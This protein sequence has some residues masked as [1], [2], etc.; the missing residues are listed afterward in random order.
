MLQTK[1]FADLVDEIPLIAEVEQV[2]CV[3][4]GHE[5]RGTGGGLRQ[6][7][8]LQAAALVAGGLHPGGSAGQ[9]LVQNAGGH[10]GAVL[11]IHIPDQ[12]HQHI[13]AGLGRDEDDG[14]VAHKAETLGIAAALQLHGV[15]L[16][17][18]HG[19]PLVHH[20]NA[21][22]ALL[23]GVASHLAVLLG[24]ADGSIHKDQRHA[25]ALHSGQCTHHHVAL[26]AIAD[27]AALAQTCG[28]GK[29][30]LAV[31]VVHRG[32]D[33]IT[34]GAGLV[35]NDHAV[36]AQ[37]AVGQ[38]GLAHVGATDDGNRD[39]VLLYHGLAEVQM[40]AHG[41]QQITRAVTVHG[42]NGH[43]LV[44]TE[45][46]ELVQLHGSLAH[47]VALVHGKNNG[48]VAAAQH[49]RHILIGCGQAVAHV[50]DHDDAVGGVNG[51]LRLLA[52]VGQNALGS[53]WLDA[54]GI[55]QQ[56]LVAVP[57]A[58]GKNAVAGNARGILHN[59]KAL[60]AQLIEQGGFAH[61]GAAH[62]CYDRFA[63]GVSSFL[64]RGKIQ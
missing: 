22:L 7:V 24:K 55:H 25:A 21:G 58:V 59:G 31:G 41:I 4:E 36:L 29:D 56:K 20:N 37:N 54:A 14:C 40:G 33:G 57:L 12:L 63:H 32:V 52:H 62:H 10:A 30:E 6:V 42:R 61:V 60:A 26:Q 38:A 13:V 2:L 17:A 5:R 11:G 28:I 44:K 15:G 27:V 1:V 3:H 50:R 51:D 8:D 39:T 46:V 43:H 49:V 48:L 53:L 16:L 47:L 34:G 45:V 18:F 19:I 9:H 64:K 23:V 35:S